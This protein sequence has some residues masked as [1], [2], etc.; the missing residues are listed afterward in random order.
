MI[1]SRTP[2]RISFAGGGSDLKSYYSRYGGAVLSTSIDKYTYLSMHPYF[3]EEKIFLKYSSNE[4]TD[5]IES[6]K[7]PLIREI[8]K[9]FE[10][11]GVDFNSSADIPS[12]TGL[13]SSSAF[14]AGL[15]NLCAAYKGKYINKQEIAELACRVEI[16]FLQEPIGKQDQYAC[17]VG[18]LNF[19]EFHT[20]D[21]VSIEKIHLSRLIQDQLESNLM[22]FYLGRTRSA[23]SVLKEQK[24][25]IEESRKIENL[26]KMVKLAYALKE[27]LIAQKID[28]VGEILHTGWMYKKELASGISDSYIDENYELA[29]KNGALGG[30]LLGAG[31]GGFLLFYVPDQK[32]AAVRNA[33]SHLMEME[34][35]FEN[36]GT[37]IIF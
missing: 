17:A 33:L 8:F 23:G 10:I 4:Y 3:A 28:S 30:K 34:F 14:A 35:K 7:H 19:I 31:G 6:I 13:A 26:H 25:N 37:T 9:Y 11:K 24:A 22:M 16:E 27:E 2:F 21:H 18:G 36:S 12:G 1:I 29:M 5:D 15:I 20:N 32:K